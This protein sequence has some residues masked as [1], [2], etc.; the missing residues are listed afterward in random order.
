[1]GKEKLLVAISDFLDGWI[2]FRRGMSKAQVSVAGRG[3]TAAGQGGQMAC[4][5]REK[6]QGILM[7]RRP[8]RAFRELAGMLGILGAVAGRKGRGPSLPK[9]QVHSARQS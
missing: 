3:T 7:M 1:M 6:T 2:C 9:I 5:G 8:Q 4:K